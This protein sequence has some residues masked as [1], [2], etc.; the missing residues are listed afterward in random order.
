MTLGEQLVAR[1]RDSGTDRGEFKYALYRELERVDS[2]N[3]LAEFL[4]ANGFKGVRV[5]SDVA[6]VAVQMSK[7]MR[8]RSLRTMSHSSS[9]LG[10]VVLIALGAG[11]LEFA[12]LLGWAV[13]TSGA[14]TAVWFSGV[15]SVLK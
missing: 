2:V 5:S 14:M 3:S 6:D 1:L 13:I 15:R 12:P 9:A 11:L 10:G 8:D 4:A 7:R